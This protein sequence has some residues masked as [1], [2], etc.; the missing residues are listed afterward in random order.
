MYAQ[1]RRVSRIIS[2]MEE[3]I[4]SVQFFRIFSLNLPFDAA[5]HLHRYV[6]S[7]VV[8]VECS[9]D[10]Q[11][12]QWKTFPNFHFFGC[13]YSVGTVQ[14]GSPVFWGR[15]LMWGAYILHGA[16]IKIHQKR[17]IG[18][19]LIL[20][21]NSFATCVLTLG[22]FPKHCFSSLAKITQHKIILV[23]NVIIYTQIPKL[24]W[25]MKTIQISRTPHHL[26]DSIHRMKSSCAL[27]SGNK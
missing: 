26:T 20:I 10:G 13:W 18:I 2:M 11:F 4:S 6:D 24:M 9:P 14:N 15:W 22:Y 12:H 25:H 27:L 16:S 19:E 17:K 21:T 8:P 1:I 7:H 3:Q 23:D 5:E